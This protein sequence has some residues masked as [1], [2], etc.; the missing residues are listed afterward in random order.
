MLRE[1]KPLGAQ[2]NEV[3]VMKTDG[4]SNYY[5]G[6]LDKYWKQFGRLFQSSSKILP[7][8][9]DASL[10]E[11][12]IAE[13]KSEFR[14]VLSELPFIGGDKNMLTFTFVSSAVALAYIRVLEKH[15]LSVDTIGIVLNEVYDYVFTSLPGFIQWLLKWSEFSSNRQNKL[16]AFAKESQLREYPGNWVMEY[17]EGNGIDFDFGCN[18]TECATLKFFQEMRAEKYMPYVCV[19]DLTYSRALHTGLHRT[20]TLFY[21][22]P[23]CDFRYKKNDTSLPGLPLEDLPEYK[24]RR[25]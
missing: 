19:M 15:G 20:T 12:V 4:N 5:L 7:K 3:N 1:A 21:G 23:Y 25:T 13:T 16:K 18:Y 10:T 6:R 17:V 14:I 2:H 9:L 8:Y 11:N 24:N 22:G